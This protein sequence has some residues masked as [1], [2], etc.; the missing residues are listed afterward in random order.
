MFK[1]I[2]YFT[3]N[4]SPDKFIKLLDK[5]G[6]ILY[7]KFSIKLHSGEDGK[8]IVDCDCCSVAEDPCINDAKML[9]SLDPFAIDQACIDLIYNSKDEGRDH[10]GDRVE[11]QHGTHILEAAS[12]LNIGNREYDLICID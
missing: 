7:G 11:R 9:A 5:L 2:V 3:K 12:E 4:I 8:F 1:S 6:I 10:F